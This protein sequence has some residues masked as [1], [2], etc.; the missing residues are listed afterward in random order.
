MG[1]KGAVGDA[2]D[3]FAGEA[4]GRGDAHAL[5]DDSPEGQPDNGDARSSGCAAG[6]HGAPEVPCDD[7]GQRRQQQEQPRQPFGNTGE[8]PVARPRLGDRPRVELQVDGSGHRWDPFGEREAVGDQAL[9]DRVDER[10][11]LQLEL[12]LVEGEGVSEGS[13]RAAT[14]R[15]PATSSM[16]IA[17]SA[18]RHHCFTRKASHRPR[19]RA[20]DH[21]PRRSA[22][23]SHSPSS[24]ACRVT[25]S[26]S[27]AP[28]ETSLS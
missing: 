9:P 3:R 7:Q 27:S 19:R 26:S 23:S 11:E 10:P 16:R 28:R 5:A 25:A 13:S 24:S 20:E 22:S 2:C 18:V 15:E 4:V 14:G 6:D 12:A 8:Q 17:T 1:P 21:S